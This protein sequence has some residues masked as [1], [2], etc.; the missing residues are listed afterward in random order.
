MLGTQVKVRVGCALVFSRFTEPDSFL[1]VSVF[2]HEA[3]SRHHRSSHSPNNVSYAVNTQTAETKHFHWLTYTQTTTDALLGMAQ[4]E[5][6]H[7]IKN[8][9][10]PSFIPVCPTILLDRDKS[11]KHRNRG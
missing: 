2:D 6:I 5:E 4:V 9:S 10:R 3:L 7:L 1:S 11:D 8:C